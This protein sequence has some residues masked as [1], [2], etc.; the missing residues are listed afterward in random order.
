MKKLKHLF[1]CATMILAFGCL[2]ACTKED[3]SDNKSNSETESK[4]ADSVDKDT[5]KDTSEKDTAEKEPDDKVT[6]T[7]K[8]VDEEGNAVANAMVQICSESCIPGKTDENGV[9]TFE[10]DKAEY[11]A[12]FITLPEGYD[13]TTEETDFYFDGEKTELTITLKAK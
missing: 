8:V 5:E 3:N 9:A 10:V 4:T 11:K 2:F 6:Y 7:V 12:S 13:Y 1:L